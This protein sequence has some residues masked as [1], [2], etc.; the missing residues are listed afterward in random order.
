MHQF[1]RSQVASSRV[2]RSYLPPDPRQLTRQYEARR[3]PPVRPVHR[4]ARSSRDP[5]DPWTWKA[6]RSPEAGSIW[7][8]RLAELRDAGLITYSI[9]KVPRI[10]LTALG[11]TKV[12]AQRADI[13]VR[14]RWRQKNAATNGLL[15][16]LSEQDPD[17]QRWNHVDGVLTSEHA[18][19]EGEQLPEGLFRLAAQ[20]LQDEGLI[21]G[22]GGAAEIRGPVTAQITFQGQECVAHG[23]D[24]ADHLSRENDHRPNITTTFNAPV[25]GNIALHNKH[26]SQ[27]FT[28]TSGRADDEISVLVRAIV[29]ALP[30]LGL[31]EEHAAA[32]RSNTDVIEGELARREQ[33]S[34]IVKTMMSRTVEIITGATGSTLGLVLT[35]Y[36]KELMR[37]A[38]L[39]I[40]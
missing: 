39:P 34:N 3:L 15:R 23:G 36:A 1:Q 13:E 29:E 10:T 38:G 24:V 8:Y 26:V 14:R 6:G 33:D 40:D 18:T 11:R 4:I 17:G 22:D 25:S 16:W 5:A 27:G 31:P 28:T 35:G 21:R 37:N 32:V 7:Q 19:F 9:D 30:A 12:E 2:P 20:Y